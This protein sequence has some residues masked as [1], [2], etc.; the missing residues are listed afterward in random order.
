MVNVSAAAAAGTDG[1]EWLLILYCWIFNHPIN[2]TCDKGSLDGLG[3]NITACNLHHHF[4]V[5]G[6]GVYVA[7]WQKGDIR[8]RGNGSEEAVFNLLMPFLLMHVTLSLCK[9]GQMEHVG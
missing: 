9:G 6:M 1:Q 7:R 8:R 5:T 3:K 2:L 4:A